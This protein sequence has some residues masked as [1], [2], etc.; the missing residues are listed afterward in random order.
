[1]LLLLCAFLCTHAKA[2]AGYAVFST[3]LLLTDWIQDLLLKLKPA[4]STQ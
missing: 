1:M 4:V 2:R 3:A